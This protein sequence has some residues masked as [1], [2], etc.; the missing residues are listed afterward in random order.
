MKTTID[1]MNDAL[2]SINFEN[3]SI[4]IGRS[5]EI[6]FTKLITLVAYIIVITF[7]AFFIVAEQIGRLI[8]GL[9]QLCESLFY[10]ALPK[11]KQEIKVNRDKGVIVVDFK[12]RK[13]VNEG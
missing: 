2:R 12:N 9:A 10:L 1:N 13:K 8:I 6:L 3:R 4:T 5:F 11:S 7:K